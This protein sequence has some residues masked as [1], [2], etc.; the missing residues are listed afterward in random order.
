MGTL[1]ACTD[2]RHSHSHRKCGIEASKLNV[3]LLYKWIYKFML[4]CVAI[5][6]TYVCI[7][8]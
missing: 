4:K 5:F 2:Y 7:A 3:M 6:K 8:N 1:N